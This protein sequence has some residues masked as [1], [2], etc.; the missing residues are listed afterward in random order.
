MASPVPPHGGNLSAE[1]RRLGCDPQ[2]LL[3]ASASLVPFRPPRSLRR[4]LAE[5]IRG[6]ALRD[7]PDR[8]QTELRLALAAH[9]GI[10][11]DALLA[12]NGAAELF[13]WAARDASVVGRS[14]VPQ[15]GFADYARAL[16]CWQGATEV[17]RLPLAWSDAWP[18]PFPH[19]SDSVSGLP[20][21]RCLWITNPHNP[22]GQLWDRSSLARLLP[23]YALVICDEAFLP[24]APEGEAHSLVPLVRGFPNLVV[25]RSLTKLFAVAGLRLGYVVAHPDRLQRWKEWRDPWS[26]NGLAL[27]AGAAVMRDRSGLARWMARVHGWV[28][29]EEPWLRGQLNQLPGL[30]AHPSSVNFLLIEGC[31]SLLTIRE[32]LSRRGVLLR[33]C[34]SFEGLGERWLRIG[35][36]SRA[37]NRRI[38]RA[39]RQELERQPLV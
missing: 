7:Y 36:Q 33:D 3:D 37:N 11:P 24:L 13:T 38:V 17:M 34:R 10:D 6:S 19:H 31:S 18:Q 39:L 5:A 9:H 21:G 30:I 1:A 23:H 28:Q 2:R 25:I 35:L 15:P 8:S 4:A 32:G 26:V 14:L 12:G 22:T 20:S 29:R 16:H 27:A